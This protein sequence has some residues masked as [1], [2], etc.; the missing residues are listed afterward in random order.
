MFLLIVISEWLVEKTFCRHLGTAL[1][2]IVLMAILSNLKI[3][4]ANSTDAPIYDLIFQ[5]IAPL[6]IF[7]LLLE[8]NLKDIVKAGLPLLSLFL[9]GSAGI[10]LG[11]LISIHIVGGAEAIGTGY[12]AIAGMF[13]GTYT[14]GGL[15]FNAVALHYDVVKSGNL[16]AG[17]VAVDNVVTTIWM[18]VTIAIPK[19]LVRL[20]KT[21][22]N[23]SVTMPA[24]EKVISVIPN[25]DHDDSEILN[26]VILALL[27]GLGFLTLWFSEYVANFLA[28]NGIQIPSILILST[29]ALIF[30]HVSYINKLTGKRLL[31]LITVYFFLAVIGAFADLSA[32]YQIG[33]LGVVLFIFASLTVTVHAVLT[34]F[35]GYLFKFDWDTV[36]VASQANVGGSTSALALAKSFERQDL[37]VPAVL[38]G[39]LGNGIGTYLGFIMAGIL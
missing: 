28:G 7:F 24:K 38:V 23:A 25:K 19:I 35:T 4:P 37:I 14:G 32:L 10:F 27:P 8:V 20:F 3:V 26:P 2:V 39:T 5:Y 21:N 30:A 1:L 6:G 29:I 18:V 12:E 22:G 31:G 15:N 17:A 16:Y 33:R 11:V 36:A 34:I 13:T 9:V